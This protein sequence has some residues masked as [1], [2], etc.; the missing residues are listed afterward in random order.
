MKWPALCRLITLLGVATTG[1]QCNRVC[2]IYTVE[3]QRLCHIEP[4]SRAS[5][6][7]RRRHVWNRASVPE[8]QR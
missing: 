1:A 7:Q 4:F 6:L 8:A 3:G 5:T 2:R